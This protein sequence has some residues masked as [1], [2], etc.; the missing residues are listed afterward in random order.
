MMDNLEE[1]DFGGLPV[2]K[3][4][5]VSPKSEVITEAT[6]DDFGGLPIL[7][8]KGLS[9][10]SG[11][12]SSPTGSASPLQDSFSIKPKTPTKNYY[13]GKDYKLEKGILFNKDNSIYAPSSRALSGK[14]PKDNTKYFDV[15]TKTEKDEVETFREVNVE[16]PKE[17]EGSY[18]NFLRNFSQ[19]LGERTSDLSAATYAFFRNLN[20]TLPFTEKRPD[21]YKDGQ[22]TEYGKNI[23]SSD[24]LGLAIK[25]FN[26]LKDSN[27]ELQQTTGKLP[28]TGLGAVLGGVN[29]I[30]PDLMLAA[31][32]R[33]GSI[34][35]GTSLTAKL[36][37][38]L[39]GAFVREQAI[40]GAATGYNKAEKE[41]GVGKLSTLASA[42]KQSAESAGQA[43]VYEVGNVFGNML[44]GT[45]SK[46]ISNSVGK[47][48]VKVASRLAT[49]SV[50]APNVI[51]LASKGE[52]ATGEEMATNLGVAG[53]ME[54]FHLG[55]TGTN[56]LVEGAVNKGGE[57]ELAQTPS[58]YGENL[59]K[60]NQ[61]RNVSAFN[62]FMKADPDVV[63][64][65]IK[66]KESASDL[67]KAAMDA[68]MKS[69]QTT[70]PV[71]KQRLDKTA[72]DLTHA[73]DIKHVTD[74]II[75]SRDGL[76]SIVDDLPPNVRD[77][78][79]QKAQILHQSLNPNENQKQN[80][81]DEITKAEDII[82]QNE[83]LA[84]ETNPNVK[85]R[86]EAQI[87]IDAAKKIAEENKN[88]YTKLSIEQEKIA[89]TPV[90][91]VKVTEE[92]KET[93]KE[94]SQEQI[95]DDIK[96]KRFASFT[97]KSEAEVPDVFKDK[98]VSRGE[99]TLPNGKVE[100]FVKVT[101]PQSIADYELG[102]TEEVKPAKTYQEALKEKQEAEK[103]QTREIAGEKSGVTRKILSDS[104]KIEASDARSAALK[105]LTGAKL[106]WDAIDEVV[107]KVKRA[108]LNT[109]ERELKSEEARVRDYVA[110]KGEGQSLDEASH[111][112]WENLSEEMQ[113]KMT[114]QD[115][116]NALMNVISEHPSK[117][118]AAKS[119]IEGYK[120]ESLDEL[121]RRYYEKYGNNAE[122]QIDIELKKGNNKEIDIE[123]ELINANYESEQQFQ[124]AYWNAKEANNNAKKAVD[125]KAKETKPTEKEPNT[126]SIKN[127]VTAQERAVKGLPEVEVTMKR[128]FPEV[129]EKAKKAVDEG[130]IDPRKLAKD[131]DNK[132]RALSAEESVALLYDR[133]RIQNEYSKLAEDIAKEPEGVIKDLMNVKLNELED[134][135]LINDAAAKKTG[136]E[137]GLGLGIRQAMIRE[138]Y[139]YL[140]QLNRYRNANLG[141]EI[142]PEVKKQLEENVVKLEEAEKKLADYEQKIKDLEAKKT[143]D[144]EV[145]KTKK[146]N[147]TDED[148]KKEREDIFKNIKDKWESASKSNI[149]TA[150]PLPYSAQ[151]AAISPEVLKLVRSYAEQGVIKLDDIIN[152]LH[153]N[154]SKRIPEITKADVKNIL[155]GEYV[156]KRE[157]PPINKDKIKLQSDIKKIQNQIDLE[158][159]IIK[160]N[161]RSQ[162]QKT[163]DY[164]Q[165]WRRAALLSGVKVL[166]KIGLSGTLRASVTTPVESLIGKQVLARIPGIKQVAAKAPREGSSSIKAEA[167]A[168]SQFVDKST[169]KDIRETL[170]TGRSELDY[171]HDKK[172]YP[173]QGWIDFFG[174]LH[175][176]IKVLPKRAEYF[177]SL[178]IRAE[179]ALKNGKD[180]SDPFVQQEIAAGAY[181]DAQR[182]IYMQDNALTDLYKSAV[183]KLES[184]GGV[185]KPV[186][187]TLKFML[188]IVKVPTNYVAEEASYILG[189]VKALYALR[190]GV[191]KLSA[192]EADY[193]MRA[194]KKQSIG[195]G[196]M[197]LG[198]ARPD[199]V[200]GYYTGPRRKDDLE[201]GSLKVFDIDMPHW[202]LHTPLLEA[203]QFGATL[204][205]QR[206]KAGRRYHGRDLN[207]FTGVSEAMIG[208]EKQVPFSRVTEDLIRIK[209]IESFTKYV[210][211]QAQ[212]VIEPQLIKEIAEF[213]DYKNGKLTKRDAKTFVDKLKTGIPGLRQQVKP[214]KR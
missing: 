7:K 31:L 27:A 42:A 92:E 1:Q 146:V 139:T 193:V 60:L 142:S 185:G 37:N 134:A 143:I 116:K 133:K 124:D 138:D 151:L 97:Y 70:D 140:N 53:A 201:S 90:E 29:S 9:G 5:G 173:P 39:T 183:R 103:K 17:E 145:K 128:T 196:F 64:N 98:I 167:Q 28:D 78:F 33:G 6:S 171:L 189:G 59:I 176:A 179:Y 99:N 41:G 79:M 102:K 117:V 184:M 199:A 119:L 207:M 192:D 26:A 169:Y 132:P 158:K 122:A 187:E 114:T 208:V 21:I 202:A 153:E 81:V 210:Q 204:R 115:I 100:K 160:R 34:A 175:Q 152:D 55:L 121:E 165:A 69:E 110:K 8:K 40:A 51:S 131:L 148:F 104:D 38:A 112:I 56:K 177:R 23:P 14:I 83:P 20:G 84:K 197:M 163:V 209:N 106:S 75:N 66:S 198:Y 161:N 85:E 71:E 162:V 63:S 58:G 141:K 48:A 19:K 214:K 156:K 147:R 137:Q 50:G 211:G 127:A 10:L 178:E 45:L 3:K 195:L 206:D 4:S 188:P 82:K 154:L 190:K 36:A 61:L 93:T 113:G 205:R 168:F 44:G 136:Y 25:G 213:S 86:L 191:S 13:G 149:V 76:S 95:Q 46:S 22:L 107:G 109:G 174:Q 24:Y 88:N 47:E 105:Y 194:L 166:G 67:N 11:E 212:S 135:A 49:I 89:Q 54:L 157:A 57:A 125:T 62:N 118:E 96:N 159:E 2:L 16:T 108:K 73:A 186:A 91:E 80:N 12:A 74:L 18:A 180:L 172:I 120:E 200:G 170:K 150:V 65:L 126:T 130:S 182:A 87:K 43:A 181:K 164:F 30:A 101:V 52:L 72:E 155:A 35:S 144:S 111:S 129:F 94:P 15:N 68:V 32:T 203:L 123:E 77:E